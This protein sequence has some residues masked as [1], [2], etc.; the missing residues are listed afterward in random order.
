MGCE[1]LWLAPLPACEEASSIDYR[2]AQPISALTAGAHEEKG[3]KCRYLG[4]QE[5]PHDPA[6]DGK[7]ES[8][9]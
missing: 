8:S 9:S 3:R 7:T 5:S 1:P 2:A 4:T 6:Q